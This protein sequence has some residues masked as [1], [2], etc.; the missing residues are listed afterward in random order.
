MIEISNILEVE[1][2]LD[3]IKVAIFDLD[4]TL[5]SEKDYIKSG[6]DAIA[7]EFPEI[8][9]MSEKLWKIFENGG[10]AIDEVLRHENIFTQE[11]LAKCLHIYRFHYPK[12][13]LYS[14]VKE[15]FQRIKVNGVKLGIISDGRPEG[16]HS[17]IDALGIRQYFDKIVITDELGGIE[18]RKPNS[19]AF[20]VIKD[21][22]G[23]RYAQMFYVGDNVKKD[24]K[25]PMLL[26]MNSIYFKNQLGLY[27]G[28]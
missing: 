19:K 11:N 9:N 28:K 21:F 26:G 8:P 5:Y 23:V 18:F 22:F 4:D 10:K 3:G 12:I 6:Y 24:F 1:N 15:L 27:Y 14:G 7:K 20:E 13:E 2:Y 25:A 16:Q 17:K